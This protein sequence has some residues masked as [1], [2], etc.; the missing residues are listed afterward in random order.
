[1]VKDKSHPKEY[2]NQKKNHL[3]QT[4]KICHNAQPI[5]QNQTPPLHYNGGQVSSE[6]G[7]L[8]LLIF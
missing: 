5:C 8:K 4:L 7:Q 3:M 1:M 6:S 2:R